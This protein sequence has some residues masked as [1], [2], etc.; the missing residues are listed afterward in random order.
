MI[1]VGWKFWRNSAKDARY[2]ELQNEIDEFGTKILE[3][4]A[5]IDHF[6]KFF[7]TTLDKHPSLYQKV[8]FKIKLILDPF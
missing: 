7:D 5:A 4:C 6:G 8:I 2:H 1:D 3:K